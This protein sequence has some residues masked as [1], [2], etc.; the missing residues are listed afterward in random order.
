MAEVVGAIAST[1]TIAALFKTCIDAF[2][3]IR[4]SQRQEA[5][6]RKLSLRLNIEKCRLYTWGEAMGLTRPQGEDNSR[7]L[8]SHQFRDVVKE[9]LSAI[10]NMFNDAERIRHEYGC[11]KADLGH[12]LLSERDASST[13]K[14]LAASFSN[15][16][17][18]LLASDRPKKIAQRSL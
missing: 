9:A 16:K 18:R 5:D 8:D 2:D 14:H 11:R 1:L 4:A 15:F 17:I 7:P 13:M 6:L 12:I 10:I 3:I